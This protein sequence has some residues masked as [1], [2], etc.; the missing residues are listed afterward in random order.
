M[1]LIGKILSAHGVKGEVIFEH[2]LMSETSFETWDALMIELLSDS[3][4]PFFIEK[5]KPHSETSCLV[6]LEEIN[7]PEAAQQIVQKNVFLSPNVLVDKVVVKKVADSYIGFMLY[8]KEKMVGIIDNILNP[9]TNPL[10]IINDG[11]E[12]ELL[13]PANEELI[14]E[15]K[16]KE[17][18]IVAD[19]PNGLL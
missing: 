5:I 16:M 7:S 8:D 15:I 2:N 9:K 4:I 10:F 19:V 1:E 13:I 3:H 14:I 18:I 11:A 12:N 6:K 17:K